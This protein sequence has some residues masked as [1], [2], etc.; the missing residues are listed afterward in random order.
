[1]EHFVYCSDRLL[2]VK[3]IVERHNAGCILS[4]VLQQ[5]QSVIQILNDIPVA[6]DC[7][8]STHTSERK[9]GGREPGIAEHGLTTKSEGRKECGGVNHTMSV[10]QNQIFTRFL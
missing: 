10:R 1:M 5:N 4:P 3:L 7:E 2:H 6:G 8:N 9:R